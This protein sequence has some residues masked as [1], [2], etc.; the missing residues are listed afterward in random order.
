MLHTFFAEIKI[1]TED[2]KTVFCI[3][4]LNLCL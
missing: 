1:K 3:Q 2:Q 4:E